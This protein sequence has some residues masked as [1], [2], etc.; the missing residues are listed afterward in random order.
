MKIS[1]INSQVNYHQRNSVSHNDKKFN[2]KDSIK[3]SR[4]EDNRVANPA[5]WDELSKEYDIS[6][7]SFND[8]ETVCN[9]LYEAKQISLCELGDLTIVPKLIAR[10]QAEQGYNVNP[11]LTSNNATINWEEER[12]NW[13]KEFEAQAE[14]QKKFGN[15]SGYSINKKLVN[16]LGKLL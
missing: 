12:I 6:N 13:L 1:T 3:S 11:L 9:K 8:L 10:A 14:Q 7:M 2:I 5:I 4:I 16:I 15:M